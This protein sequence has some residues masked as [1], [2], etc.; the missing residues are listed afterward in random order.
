MKDWQTPKPSGPVH[1]DSV[2]NQEKK[3]KQADWER[4][5]SDPMYYLKWF[6]GWAL[7]IGLVVLFSVSGPTREERA[8]IKAAQEEA[9][10]QA[11]QKEY[12]EISRKAA[13]ESRR[14]YEDRALAVCQTG[15]KAAAQV[16]ESVD[17]HFRYN[18]ETLPSG[19]VSVGQGFDAI[20]G[21]GMKTTNY[22]KCLFDAKGDLLEFWWNGVRQL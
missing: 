16:P 3:Q 14:Y 20:N 7:A 9:D 1:P 5:L 2:R 18:V 11:R 13:Q 8:A 17:F 21:Y 12:A 10:R 19:R 6:G 4:K 15:I 22:A